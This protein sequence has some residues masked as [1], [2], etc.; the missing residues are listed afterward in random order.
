MLELVFN[1]FRCFHVASG[2]ARLLWIVLGLC[3]VG[4]SDYFR[5]FE[6]AS[7]HFS[8]FF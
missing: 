8:T 7:I 2:C 5:M 6:V 1:C 4:C 3:C